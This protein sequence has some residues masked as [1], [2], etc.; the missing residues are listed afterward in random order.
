MLK[1]IPIPDFLYVTVCKMTIYGH[2]NVTT[3]DDVCK[4]A[5]PKLKTVELSSNGLITSIYNLEIIE[6]I[7]QADILMDPNNKLHMPIYGGVM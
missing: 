7:N 3:F 2:I 1:I 5:F 4:F 6:T